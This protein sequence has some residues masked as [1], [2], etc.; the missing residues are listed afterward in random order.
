MSAK[1]ERASELLAAEVRYLYTCNWTA[2][3]VAGPVGSVA[4]KDPE[5]NILVSQEEAIALQKYWDHWPA[6]KD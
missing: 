6:V 2:Y 4:W 3:S 5:K 1:T